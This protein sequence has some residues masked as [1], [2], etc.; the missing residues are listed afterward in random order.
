MRQLMG[1]ECGKTLALS[2][3]QDRR[4]DH[5]AQ[6]CHANRAAIS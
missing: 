1:N 2:G 4:Q 3:E 6:K 5:M